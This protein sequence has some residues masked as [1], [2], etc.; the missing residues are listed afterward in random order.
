MDFG[1]TRRSL[2]PIVAGLALPPRVLAQARPSWRPGLQLYT[3]RD[4]LST[5]VE[6]TLRRI[7]DIGYREVEL[8]G[9][10]GVTADAMRASLQRYGLDVPS[11]HAGYDELRGGLAAVLQEARVLGATCVVCPSVD[12]GQRRTAGDWKR[13][14]RTLNG[15]GRAVREQGLVLAYHNHDFEFVPFDDGT[16]PF[17]L[18]LTETDPR[19]VKLELDVYWVAKAGLDPVQ[20]LRAGQDRIV[21]VHLKDLGPD[22]STVEVGRGVLDMEKIVR[23]ALAAGARHLFV[24][25][26]DSPDPIASI[27]SSLRFLERLPADLRPQP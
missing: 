5:D 16:T 15:I 27:A 12:A 13:V 1:R 18:L 20:H 14:C 9:L 23:T 26:D 19:D 10:P 2:L 21:L 8:A 3:V 24:E 7:A 4:A 22:G 17:R 11:M 25:Q 6:G